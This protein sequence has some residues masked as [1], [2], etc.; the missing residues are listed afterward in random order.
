M[1]NI[2][3]L[4]CALTI[5]TL[6]PAPARAGDAF[7]NFCNQHLT[8]FIAPLNLYKAGILPGELAELSDPAYVMEEGSRVRKIL[9]AMSPEQRANEP[10]EFYRRQI[11]YILQ[12]LTEIPQANM[13][14]KFQFVPAGATDAKLPKVSFADAIAKLRSD[15][16]DMLDLKNATPTNFLNFLS[17]VIF[18]VA[19]SSRG[20][21]DEL[22]VSNIAYYKERLVK[23]VRAGIIP[24]PTFAPLNARDFREFDLG[25]APLGLSFRR[26]AT[27]DGGTSG[28]QEFFRHDISHASNALLDFYQDQ[29]QYLPDYLIFR[30]SV[31]RSFAGLDP[32]SRELMELTWF[33]WI[34]EELGLPE[35]VEA[36][37]SADQIFDRSLGYKSSMELYQVVERMI[38]EGEGSNALRR[39]SKKKRKQLLMDAEKQFWQVLNSKF[40]IE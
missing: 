30:D 3:L 5:S 24:W 25:L 20:P 26:T 23:L 38:E 35:F 33:A 18:L 11:P 10:V 15:A 6:H 7:A 31:M 9:Q 12:L 32:V 14:R 34:H 1:K 21:A 39:T 13:T 8:A 27:Y 4:I 29:R 37:N 22:N 17:D 19:H 36:I 28:R 16:H 40:P 2:F